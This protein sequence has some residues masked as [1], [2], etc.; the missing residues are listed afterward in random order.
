M[1]YT[2]CNIHWFYSF[3]NLLDSFI[4]MGFSHPTAWYIPVSMSST[5]PACGRPGDVH[6]RSEQQGDNHRNHGDE[7]RR[8]VSQRHP[9]KRETWIKVCSNHVDPPWWRKQQ[10][11]SSC[12]FNMSNVLD[13]TFFDDQFPCMI[14]TNLT[15]NPGAQ[16]LWSFEGF[17]SQ[18]GS[19]LWE[20]CRETH[21]VEDGSPVWGS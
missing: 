16:A 6:G 21:G 15:W 3:I 1:V 19:V 9:F 14:S 10:T 18:H 13:Q 17:A 11:V 8:G 5:L 12:A 7:D 4:H 20:V 2:S